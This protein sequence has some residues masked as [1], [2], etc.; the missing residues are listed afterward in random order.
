MNSGRFYTPDPWLN[1]F[2]GTIENRIRKCIS[3]EKELTGDMSLSEFACG[4]KY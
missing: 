1:P 4:H 3:K 2:T